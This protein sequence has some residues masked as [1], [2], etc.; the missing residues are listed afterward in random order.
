MTQQVRQMPIGMQV[1]NIKKFLVENGYD[2]ESIDVAAY[3][4]RTL[5]LSENKKEF[6]RKLGIQIEQMGGRARAT[7][8]KNYSKQ[9]RREIDHRY[10]EHLQNNCETECNNNACRAY[11]KTGCV[12]VM[13]IVNPCQQQDRRSRRKNITGDCGVIAYCVKAH[14]RPPQHNSR[15]GKPIQ[16]SAYCVDIHKR[17][18]RRSGW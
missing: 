5:S 12:P 17:M 10:C 3:V 11:A 15:T 14:T 13:G 18:C 6:A 8:G 2:P 1:Y 7:S 4:D 16:V 9:A